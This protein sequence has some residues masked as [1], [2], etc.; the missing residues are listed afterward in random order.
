[1]LRWQTTCCWKQ[2]P[3]ESDKIELMPKSRGFTL[4]DLLVVRAIM[5]VIGVYTL[6]SYRSFGEDQN[7]KNAVLDVVSLL[8]QAQTNATANV[9]CN[10]GTWPWQVQFVNST[11]AN[12]KCSGSASVVKSL[13]PWDQSISIQSFSGTSCP[14]SNPTVNF[15]PLKGSIEFIGFPNCAALTVT[16]TNTKNTKS[17]IIEQGGRIY[18]E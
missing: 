2:S 15:I 1:M 17:L 16:L 5:A 4:I 18:A 8:R 9:V 13:P 3:V 10:N 7:L 14:T 6:S 12:L 11:T